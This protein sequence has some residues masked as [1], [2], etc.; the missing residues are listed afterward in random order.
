MKSVRTIIGGIVL[1]ITL[2]TAAIAGPPA[3]RELRPWGAQRGQTVTL[4]VAGDQLAA[5]AELFSAVPGKIEEQAGGNAGQ[6]TFKLDVRPDAPVGVYPIRLRTP[7]GLSNVLL[8]SVG[9]LPEAAETE[10]NDSLPAMNQAAASN[11]AAAAIP[12]VTLPATVN[13]SAVGTDQDV[14]RFVGK[15]GERIVLEVEAQRIGS[16]LDPA[17]HLYSPSGRELALADETPGL[18]LDC[19]LDVT[20]PEDGEY[21]AVVHDSKYAGGN[22]GFY[23]L[24]LG[25][26]A[27]AETAFPLGWQRGREV[28][29]TLLGGTLAEPLK[30]KVT[31]NAAAGQN[32]MFLSPLVPGP[33][34]RLP[35]RFVLGDAPE[36]IEPEPDAVDQRLFKDAAV[37]NGQIAK[38]GEVDRY[39]FPVA[40][41][42]NWIFEVE[43]AN[44]G[45]PLD[46]LL[47]VTGPQGNVLASADDGNGLDPRLQFAVPAGIDYV[48]LSI[49]DLH[50]RGG[51]MFAYRL[52][53]ET[54]RTDFSL[55]VAPPAPPPAPGAP[56]PLGP[57]AVNIPR[58][59]TAVVQVN[60][61]RSGYN[62]PIQLT[63]PETANGITAEDGSIPAGAATGFLVLSAAPDAPLRAFDLEI[64]GQGGAATKPMV[65]SAATSGRNPNTMSDAFVARVPA[66]VC[67]APPATLA[68]SERSI[69]LVHGHNRQIKI[70][71]QRSPAATE[72]INVNGTGLPIGVVSGTT[73]VI[74]KEAN[75]LV[76]T[77]VCSP[78]NPIIGPLTM[79]LSATTQ[80]GGRQETIELPPVR[81]EIAR[82]FALELLNQNV[83]IAAGSKVRVAVIVRREAPFAGLVKVGPVGSIPQNVSLTT[84]DVPNGESLALLE[85]V[86][87]DAAVPAEFD[88]QIRASTDMEGRK[89][90]KDYV[91]PDTPLK[92]KITPKAAQ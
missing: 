42:Q 64:N 57:P 20:L 22:P 67:E 9:E 70:T 41:G 27:Y 54:P 90:D 66:A 83:T 31:A 80:A 36:L 63:I 45:S 87:G 3:I 69:R 52:K 38:T 60:V 77:L 91:I 75:E 76:L 26:F 73:G 14:V 79:Q 1:A 37:M 46:A 21:S 82:P 92:V 19:R 56:Q 39:K 16:M 23:R 61:A 29:V 34:A 10:P 68:P 40:A 7:N 58:G 17:I 15:K 44:L 11:T 74:A 84:L 2:C 86:V 59:G 72:A 88:L 24:K 32:R 78:E 85:L 5:G 62:G 12:L 18:G 48:V 13:V 65:R 47:T 8:F 30:T 81:V 25:A 35:F 6:L 53:A 71:A 28:E 49:E 89:R 50:G 33:Q 43:A 51:P 55:Q 4:V